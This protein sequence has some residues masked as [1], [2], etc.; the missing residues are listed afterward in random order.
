MF[1]KEL[2]S[3]YEGKRV[4]IC[5]ASCLTG[6]N[7]FDALNVLG[8]KVFGTCLT[9][10]HY[11]S[12]GTPMFRVVDFTDKQQ[13]KRAF[14]ERYDYVF[15]CAAQSY[16]AHVCK[17]SPEEL[18]LPNIIMTSNILELAKKTK[19]GRVMFLSS[20]VTY[21]PHS[22]PM[23]E[24]EIDFNIDPSDLY[25]GIGWV[26]RYLE[27]LC[28]FYS[29]LG[30]PCTIVRLTNV[31]GPYDKT[32]LSK[33]HVIPA[34]IMRG[35]NKEDPFI[36]NSKGNGIKSF[37]HVN[38]VVRDM[39]KAMIVKGDFNVFNIT[40]NESVSIR[41]MASILIECLKE[42]IKGYNP[43]VI[44]KDSPD[45]VNYICL[46]R[47][48]LDSLCGKDKY[49]SLKR[50]LKDTIQWYYLSLQTQRK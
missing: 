45:A 43:K 38:D 11:Y 1:S 19:C 23:R 31:Y 34:L 24:D 8:A 39:A 16:N 14:S 6:R 36:I 32:D 50:G 47:D 10:Q 41:D 49:I 12:D 27:K 21:Q 2:F 3:A 26:K 35:L 4:L 18:I 37:V 7:L 22:H 42:E 48:K 44:F 28:K 30:L 5:G 40:G 17:E 9:D 20:S 33:C 25:M 29:K 13:A 15:I 46:S